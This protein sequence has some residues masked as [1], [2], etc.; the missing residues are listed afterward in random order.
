M[1]AF[2]YTEGI[3]GAE[4][5]DRTGN[6]RCCTSSQKSATLA[7][8]EINWLSYP[9]NSGDRITLEN[10]ANKVKERVLTC[11]TSN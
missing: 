1:V 11:T 4:K 10:R 5:L 9:Y 3:V 7:E 8:K 2:S 6:T